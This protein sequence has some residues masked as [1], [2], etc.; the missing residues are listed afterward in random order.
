VKPALATTNVNMRSGPGTD[1]AIVTT[2][3]GGSTV[4]VSGCNGEWCAVTWNG[5]S[6]FAIARSLDTGARQARM[7]PPPGAYVAEAEPP[8]VYAAPGYYPPPPVVYGPGYY[9]YGPG[10]YRRGWWRW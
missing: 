9:R 8:V 10:Y 2:I 7:R 4:R 1:T 5:R 3:P 6:G